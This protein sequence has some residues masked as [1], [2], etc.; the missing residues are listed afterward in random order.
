MNLY[1]KFYGVEEKPKVVE[2]PVVKS[3]EEIRREDILANYERYSREYTHDVFL[4]YILHI[5][6]CAIEKSGKGVKKNI[7]ELK[8][9]Y[10]NFHPGLKNDIVGSFGYTDFDI[11]KIETIIDGVST[12]KTR[13]KRRVEVRKNVD[14]S[15][16]DYFANIPGMS[17]YTRSNGQYCFNYDRDS[18]IK[19]YLDLLQYLECQECKLEDVPQEFQKGRH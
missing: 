1:E 3:A 15:I 17:H 12:T 6:P 13:K 4:E 16:F 19:F 10:G 9:R 18:I 14:R 5:L 7:T 2:T 8:F 11:E